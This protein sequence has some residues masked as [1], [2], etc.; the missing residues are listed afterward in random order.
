MDAMP[1]P[2]KLDLIQV[3]FV[4][5]VLSI[6]YFFL[7]GHLFK[8]LVGLMDERDADI[9]AGAMSRMEASRQV[10]QSQ[11]AFDQRLREMNA[12]AFEHR[13]TLTEAANRE[14]EALLE[15]TRLEAGRERKVAV[16]AIRS[17]AE[18][19]EFELKLQIDRMSEQLAQHL[20]K[21]A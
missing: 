21:Q 3:A 18:K 19:A 5:A 16:D 1:D 12:E 17:Q 20:L 10:E 15:K 4:M 7:K 11:L 9:Q 14:K 6:L 2:M 8:P 13:R